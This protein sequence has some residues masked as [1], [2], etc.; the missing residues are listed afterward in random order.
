[1]NIDLGRLKIVGVKNGSIVVEAFITSSVVPLNSSTQNV[2]VSDA[3][4]HALLSLMA[5]NISNALSAGTVSVGAPILGVTTEVG[6]ISQ[7]GT[8]YVPP[9]PTT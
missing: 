7:N 3:D 9:P 4:S 1:M 2:T 6:V 5:A 8:V